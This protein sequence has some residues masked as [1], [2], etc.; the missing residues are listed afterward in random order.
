M[1]DRDEPR[2]ARLDGNAAGALLAEVFRCEPSMARA[3][4]S[5]CGAI[6]PVGALW[7]YGLEMGAVLRCPV[8]DT[9]IMRLGAAG[10]AI[11]VDLRGAVSVR[12]EVVP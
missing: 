10:T 9:A 2:E 5:G 6:A 4:C 8:C 11:V 3:V 7:A 12:F 1:S